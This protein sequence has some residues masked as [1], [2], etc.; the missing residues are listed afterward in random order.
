MQQS[1][2]DSGEAPGQ[3]RTEGPGL[4]TVFKDL[5]AALAAA[6]EAHYGPRL[7]SLVLFGS[8]ARGTMRHHS[9]IDV[10]VVAEGLPPGRMA[11]VRDFEA[12]ERA[13]ADAFATARRFGVDTSLSPLIKSPGEAAAG[14]PLYLDMVDE[15]RLLRDHGGF[16]AGI[17]ERLR[18]RLRVLGSRRVWRGNAWYWILKPDLK[19]GEVFEL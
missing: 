9:D 11:R 4:R 8:V 1:R 2:Q 5:E 19:P 6:A 10:L 18:A 12:V 7:V 15:A 14:S 13:L 17:L 16:F 3:F